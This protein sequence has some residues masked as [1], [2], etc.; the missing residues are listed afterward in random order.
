ME[1]GFIRL[2]GRCDGPAPQ[3][4]PGDS[5][6]GATR[7]RR[8]GFHAFACCSH[9]VFGIFLNDWIADHPSS[10]GGPRAVFAHIYVLDRPPAFPFVR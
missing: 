3:F 9:S 8:R 1:V 10:L 7:A 6:Q 4:S 2:T 5:K